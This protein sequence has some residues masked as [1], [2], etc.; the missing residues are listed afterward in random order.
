MPNVRSVPAYTMALDLTCFTTRQPNNMAFNSASVGR[1]RVTILKVSAVVTFKSRSCHKNESAPILRRSHG[2]ATSGDFL[3]LRRRRFFFFINTPN[4]SA[5]KSGATMTSLKI[6]EI[7]SAQAGSRAQFNTMMPP[8][9]A[10]RSV[11][12]ALSQT[13]RVHVFE[14]GQRGRV[15]RKFRDQARRG[16]Q[17]QDVIV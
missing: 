16:S 3:V 11:A 8:N 9:G 2:C 5:V 6:S 15:G 4:A 14:D 13:A 1:R 7:A 17:V 10:W 12:S